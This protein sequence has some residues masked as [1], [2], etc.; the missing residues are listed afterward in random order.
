MFNIN[1]F[2]KKNSV[3]KIEKHRFKNIFII[4]CSILII[5]LVVILIFN[6]GS[7]FPQGFPNKINYSLFRTLTHM[8]LTLGYLVVICV[9][10]IF[11][12]ILYL[13]S[14]VSLFDNLNP[15]FSELSN[16]ARDNCSNLYAFFNHLINDCLNYEFLGN[17]SGYCEENQYEDT[18]DSRNIQNN[19]S[20]KDTISPESTD[21]KQNSLSSSESTSPDLDSNNSNDDSD[22]DRKSVV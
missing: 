11:I 7:L 13:L 22:S 3:N 19:Y 20:E 4:F 18:V 16:I 17:D 15:S 6:F 1:N 12:N 10:F 5:L 8:G 9:K 2:Y 14:L 21:N